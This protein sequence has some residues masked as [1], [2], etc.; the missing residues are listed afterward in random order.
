[1][2]LKKWK[3]QL[4]SNAFSYLIDR[5]V[6]NVKNAAYVGIITV[7]SSNSV[8]AQI[9]F[10]DGP[11]YLTSGGGSFA[12]TG[13]NFFEAGDIFSPTSSGLA[14]YINFA[15]FYSIGSSIP[16][17]SFTLSLYSTTISGGRL[18]PNTLI[19]MSS[20]SDLTKTSLGSNRNGIANYEYGGSLNTPITLVMGTAYYL[21]LSDTTT[22][23]SLFTFAASTN[24]I[25][26]PLTGYSLSSSNGFTRVGSN[27]SFTLSNIA[28][29][30]E[31]SI[32]TMLLGGL[33][34]LI[35]WRK[36]TCQV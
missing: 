36:L 17:D 27:Y 28:P 35:F 12:D 31:P 22:P 5:L 11:D 14:N 23:Y 2:H 30:P 4:C 8:G 33:G 15:G 9:L 32:L 25:T 1:M 10:N 26:Q 29:V 34:L 13:N 6:L 19:S 7:I 21:G 18:V 24:A 16:S 3:R 20:V